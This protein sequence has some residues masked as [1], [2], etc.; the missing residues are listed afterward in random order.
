MTKPYGISVLSFNHPELTSKCLKSVLQWAPAKNVYL[1]HNGSLEKHVAQLK[2][3]FPEIH[4]ILVAENKGYAC[5][6]NIAL[7]ESLKHFNSVLF[8]TNDTEVICLP[9]AA[10]I[11]FSSIK[12]LRRNST[13]IDSVM[14]ALNPRIGKLKHLKSLAE[15]DPRD[16]TYVPGTAFWMNQETFMALHGFD[17]RFHTYWEDVDFSLRAHRKGIPIS[18]DENTVCRHKIGKTCHKDR[19]YTY[20][21]FQRNRGRCM[22]KNNLISVRFYLNY[23]P[24]IIKYSRSEYRRALSIFND[25]RL[26]KDVLYDCAR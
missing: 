7:T 22:T 13:E 23:I 18:Y 6:A 12:L 15:H 17:E 10:P 14:G 4:H 1:T 8:L 9:E 3:R 5:G 25:H 26:E 21:L 11:N 24:D 16:L 20:E 19:F 2:A